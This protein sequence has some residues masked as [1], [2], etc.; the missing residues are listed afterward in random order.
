M[1]QRRTVLQQFSRKSE[2]YKDL[3]QTVQAAVRR[4]RRNKLHRE[5]SGRGPNKVWKSIRSVVAGKKD[6]P[7]VQPDV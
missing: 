1:D 6:R 2:V 3:N 4:D 7:S 5:I